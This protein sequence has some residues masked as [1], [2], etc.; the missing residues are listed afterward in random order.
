MRLENQGVEDRAA[1]E[2]QLDSLASQI[3]ARTLWDEP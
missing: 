1:R 2:Q 3:D